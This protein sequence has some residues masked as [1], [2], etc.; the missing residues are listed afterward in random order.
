EIVKQMQAWIGLKESD[1][2]HKK[3][4]DIYNTIKPLPVGYKLKYTDAWCAGAVSA[5]AQA[6][7]ATDIVPAEC[8]CPRMITKA[9]NMG[10]WVETDAHKPEPGD[11][12]MY[13]WDDSGKGDNLGSPEH[14]GIVEKISGSTITV[15]EGNYSN[16]VKR[17]SLQVN[18]RYIRG[19]IVPKYADEAQVEP[20]VKPEVKT[21]YQVGLRYLKK[22]CKGEDVRA[23]QILLIGHGFTC[24][25][26]GA[27][28]DFGTNTDKAVRNYQK[29]M[30]LVVDGSVGSATMSSLLGV[31]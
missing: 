13:D 16:S 28:G 17:R 31:K 5:A 18:G 26:D 12:I 24:G 4:I 23:L 11:I 7:N 19:Y 1:G 2:S 29:A 21:D 8:S 25:P 10:I 14:V 27:D 6:C 15:I 9:K 20:E 22:G 30:G 3:I